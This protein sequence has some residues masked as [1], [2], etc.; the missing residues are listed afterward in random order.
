M[1]DLGYW[2]DPD[3][4]WDRLY[5]GGVAMPGAWKVEADCERDIEVKKSKGSD[6]ANTT[7]HGYTPASITLVGTLWTAKQWVA[8]QKVLPNLHPRQKGGPRHPVVAV[9]PALA[10]MNISTIYVK[11]MG[12]PSVGDRGE[13]EF[14][15]ECVEWNKPKK[16]DKKKKPPPTCSSEQ[17]E[18]AQHSGDFKETPE[19]PS[20]PYDPYAGY[21]YSPADRA[22][23][24]GLMTMDEGDREKFPEV[25]DNIRSDASPMSEP[26]YF[27]TPAEPI[28]ESTAP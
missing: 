27:E 16:V 3:G 12:A 10:V 6:G 26:I 5:L 11:R 19:G 13:C 9:H 15:I 1:A 22:N 8:L 7:D 24:A 17:Q 4:P 20:G 14:R 25:A 23:G 28:T 2:D 18:A 21:S